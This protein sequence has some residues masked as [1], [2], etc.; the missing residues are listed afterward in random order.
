MEQ[1]FVTVFTIR[2][3]LGSLTLSSPADGFACSF[4]AVFG[5]AAPN[6]QTVSV[7]RSRTELT[8]FQKSA[9][10]SAVTDCT[11]VACATPVGAWSSFG[12]AKSQI[13][14]TWSGFAGRSWIAT[15]AVRRNPTR[16]ID[17]SLGPCPRPRERQLADA[18]E[19]ESEPRSRFG[20]LMNFDVRKISRREP[21]NCT[22][23]AN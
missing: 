18:V 10:T 8:G 4:T 5:T 9:V 16:P 23:I 22:S 7:S 1:V 2:H 14:A 12:N 13:L 11:C 20:G 15:G 21:L 17:G 6:V 19:F 3:C